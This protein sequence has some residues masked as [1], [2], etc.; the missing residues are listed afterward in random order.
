LESARAFAMASSGATYQDIPMQFRELIRVVPSKID[1]EEPA[2]SRLRWTIIQKHIEAVDLLDLAPTIE[3]Q[4][5]WIAPPLGAQIS[6]ATRDRFTD[7]E[8]NVVQFGIRVSKIAAD[9]E[10]EELHA[11][12]LLLQAG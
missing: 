1:E 6:M 5:F 10:H 7:G 2:L 3:V 12:V 8:S 11:S 4:T 9:V